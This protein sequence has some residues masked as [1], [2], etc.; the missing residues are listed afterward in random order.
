MSSQSAF[1]AVLLDAERPVPSGLKA[2]NH[3]DPSRRFTVYRNNVVS[4]LIDAF[5]DT[6]PVTQQLVGEAF[7]RE[8]AL[9]FVRESPPTSPV[10]VEYGH[11]FP[12]FIRH[13]EPVS[14]LGYLADVARLE[15]LRLQAYHAPDQEPISEAR[16][17]ALLRE[18]A[19]LT[20]L[21]IALHP[22]TQ[23]LSSRFAAVSIWNAHQSDEAVEL[24][25]IDLACPENALVVRPEHHVHVLP[26]TP[27]GTEWV[28]S[29]MLG[30]PL[31]VSVQRAAEVGGGMD[32][33]LA[34]H[35]SILIQHRL[36]TDTSLSIEERKP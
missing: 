15:A 7:F 31:G 30:F 8:M 33:D 5:A 2:W 4:S 32:F 12:D 18:P 35:L 28:R 21:R 24:G 11:A 9:H 23:V 13:C 1:S 34:A 16:L 6:Y 22:S 27:A 17:S 26:M 36:I 20:Q 3:S 19:L 29:L 14:H 25:E 10:L